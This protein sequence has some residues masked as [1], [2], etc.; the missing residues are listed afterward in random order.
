MESKALDLRQVSGLKRPASAKNSMLGRHLFRRIMK[1][2][3]EAE[4]A[5]E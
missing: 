5:G 3:T 4:A 2:R 1:Q